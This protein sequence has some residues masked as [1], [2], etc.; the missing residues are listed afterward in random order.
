M[1]NTQVRELRTKSDDDL[2]DMYD[3]L[4]E[5]LYILRLNKSTGELIDTTE[6]RKTKRT[7]AR[8]LTILRE[9]EL[10]AAIAEGES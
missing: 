10:A 6:F 4:K 7:L 2:L 1:A 3:D 8:T 5:E 9:R